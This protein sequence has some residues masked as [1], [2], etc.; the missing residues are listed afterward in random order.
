MDINKVLR[1][2]VLLSAYQCDPTKGSEYGRSWNWAMTYL[3]EGY[4]VWCFT[5]PRGK[6]NIEA[7]LKQHPTPHL[8][9]LYIEVPTWVDRLYGNMLGVYFHY[10]IWQGEAYRVAKNLDRRVDFDLIHHVSYGSIQM[11]TSLWRLGK[12]LVMGSM[13]GGQFPMLA[14]KKYF[15]G[16]WKRELMRN[17]ISHLLEI[18]SPNM[19]QSLKKSAL[20]L[21][22][23]KETFDMAKKHGAKQIRLFVENNFP[24]AMIPPSLP[25]RTHNKELKILWVGRLFARKGLLLALE[26][27]SKIN[28]SIP[29]QLTILGGQGEVKHLVPIW[30]KELGLAPKV[31]W[32]GQVPW[33]EVKQAYQTHDLLLFTSLRESFGHQTLEAM[34]FGLPVVAL[35]ITGI[36]DVVPANC[37]IKI[38]VGTPE[39]SIQKIVEEIEYLYT[40]REKL[41]EL[42]KNGYEFAE[43]QS[44]QVQKQFLWDLYKEVNIL[45]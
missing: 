22:Q 19:R 32:R 27:L 30:L 33:E 14:F 43:R 42:S 36:R 29:F 21:V 8:Q 23:N 2:K 45:T 39:E 25:E 16:N 7:Y 41:E 10:F 24:D 5:T 31:D 34:A 18:F 38:P 1:K 3:S 35:N 40:H 12:K 9:F 11:G 15:A 20:I 4:E 6:E 13:G 17:W 28:Q 44:W 26:A 37:A